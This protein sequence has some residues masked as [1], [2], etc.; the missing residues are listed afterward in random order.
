MHW[1]RLS[2]VMYAL[3]SSMASEMGVADRKRTKRE[4]RLVPALIFR[5]EQFEGMLVRLS[6]KLK[7]DLTSQMRRSTARDFRIVLN[8]IVEVR[9]AELVRGAPPL[10]LA[11]VRPSA[12][13]RV[14]CFAHCRKSLLPCILCVHRCP[15]EE[16]EKENDEQP[17]K[18]KRT[19]KGKAAVGGGDDGADNLPEDVDNDDEDQDGE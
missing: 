16:V 18:R 19:A 10:P 15:Q 14:A 5:V 13:S 11:T 7:V 3:I 6:K 12:A 9:A 1:Q 2:R 17:K 4:A 8:K